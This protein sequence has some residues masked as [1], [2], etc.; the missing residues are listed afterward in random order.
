MP[1]ERLTPANIEAF[2]AA[3]R[4]LLNDR[5]RSGSDMRIAQ[6]LGNLGDCYYMEDQ[7]FIAY[8]WEACD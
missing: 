1:P 2:L 4:V 5:A 3:M 7:E 6:V 8:V